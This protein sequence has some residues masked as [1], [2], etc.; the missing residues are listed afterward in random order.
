M[1]ELFITSNT[2]IKK[3]HWYSNFDRS[4]FII[5]SS[6]KN[7]IS[8]TYRLY[9]D[10]SEPFITPS[11]KSKK[12]GLNSLEFWSSYPLTTPS[13]KNQEIARQQLNSDWYEPFITQST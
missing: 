3:E 1:I 8:D 7:Q 12:I 5:T 4:D 10:R 2:K 13:N 9:S 11:T 6:T